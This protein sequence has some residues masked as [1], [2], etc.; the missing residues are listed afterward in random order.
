[1]VAVD[2]INRASRSRL[3]WRGWKW[4]GGTV[5]SWRLGHAYRKLGI[6]RRW[7]LIARDDS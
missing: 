6:R 2:S 1:M 4:P 5:W 7:E 3:D